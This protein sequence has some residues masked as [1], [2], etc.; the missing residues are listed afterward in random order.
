MAANKMAGIGCALA[1]DVFSA[2]QSV[3][4]DDANAVAMGAWLVGRATVR[5]V[6]QAFTTATFDDDDDTVRRV[7]KLRELEAR[8]APEVIAQDVDA[9]EKTALPGG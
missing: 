1:H 9:P 6:L 7:A 2:Y 8:S 3:E 5:E 4:H